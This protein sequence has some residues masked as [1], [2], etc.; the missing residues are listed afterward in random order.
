MKHAICITAHKNWAQ[1]KDLIEVL[2]IPMVDIYLHI[3]LKSRDSFE[4]YVVENPIELNGGGYYL[5]ESRG[6]NWGDLSLSLTELAL[7]RAVINSNIKYDYIHLISGQDFSLKP[8]E[9]IIAECNLNNFDYISYMEDGSLKDRLSRRVRYYHFFMN[10]SR[11]PFFNFVRKSLLLPQIILGVNRLRSTH[12]DFQ[13][14]SE[15]CSLTYSSVFFL[16]K[17][18]PKYKHLFEHSSCSDECYKQMIL[19]NRRDAKFSPEGNKRFIIFDNLAPSPQTL[20][21]EDYNQIM[22]SNCF[23][24]RKFDDDVDK[25]VRLS[26]LEKIRNEQSK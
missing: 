8:I 1:L 4:K 26:I 20:T 14:G 23:F 13:V 22:S 21:S 18:F 5:I 24:A 9:S 6:C 10:R 19:Q 11:N 25:N 17:E 16:L 2:S 15:W 12:M 3:D 7:F